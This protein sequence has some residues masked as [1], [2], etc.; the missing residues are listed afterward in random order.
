LI[1][2]DD[3]DLHNLHEIEKL[4]NDYVNHQLLIFVEENV[5]QFFQ[6]PANE[7]QCM[8]IES[9][10]GCNI[11]QCKGILNEKTFSNQKFYTPVDREFKGILD[12]M[13]A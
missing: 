1:E 5:Y 10:L 9:K 7:P 3:E 12:R 2:Y 13:N 11:R 6:N 4:L 8:E